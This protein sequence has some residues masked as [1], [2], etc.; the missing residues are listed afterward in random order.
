MT[1]ADLKRLFR[2]DSDEKKI[3]IDVKGLCDI[4]ALK[5]SNLSWW[6]L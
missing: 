4:E 5:E 6:R 3:L 2:K 1:V